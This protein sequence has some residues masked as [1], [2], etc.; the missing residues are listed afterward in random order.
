[1]VEWQTRLTQ[2]QVRKC[3]GSSPAIGIVILTG[4]RVFILGSFCYTVILQKDKY[5]K[6]LWDLAEPERAFSSLPNICLYLKRLR[7]I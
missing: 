4:D 6:I 2:N 3:A 1:M 7:E 5:P